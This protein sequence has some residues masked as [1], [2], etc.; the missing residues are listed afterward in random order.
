MNGVVAINTGQHMPRRLLKKEKLKRFLMSSMSLQKLKFVASNLTKVQ[1][2]IMRSIFQQSPLF[3]AML[4]VHRKKSYLRTL[5]MSV[6][7]NVKYS[8]STLRRAT[9]DRDRFFFVSRRNKL[10]THLF[11]AFFLCISCHLRQIFL[12]INDAFFLASNVFRY[13]DLLMVPFANINVI[14]YLYLISFLGFSFQ[15]TC[16]TLQCHST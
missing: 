9:S 3:A 15:T 14:M 5:S 2:C 7:N 11:Y 1:L 8:F 16:P 4:C 12:Q 13:K 6:F 10:V